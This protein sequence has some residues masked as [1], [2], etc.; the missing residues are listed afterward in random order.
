MTIEE[1]IKE[2]TTWELAEF[3]YKVSNGDIKISK[4]EKECG[5]CNFSDAYCISEIA[6]YLMEKE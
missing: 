2:M 3:I 5:K 6:E 4:C 1:H